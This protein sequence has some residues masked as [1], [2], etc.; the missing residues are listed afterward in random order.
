[1]KAIIMAGGEGRRL[2][3]ISVLRPKPMVS[4]FDRPVMEH[5]IE[6]LKKHEIRD[7]CVTLRYLP[8]VVTDY[9]GDGSEFGVSIEYRIEDEPLGTAGGVRACSDFIGNED[10]LVISGDAVCDFNLKKCID[11]H[12][13]KKSPATIILCEKDEPLEYGLVLTD[14]N[15]RITQFIEKPSWDRVC[16]NAVNTGIYI[17]SSEVLKNIPGDRSYDFG[18]D[19]FPRLLK[20]GVPM[21]AYTAKGYWCDIGSSKAYLR[22]HFDALDGKT[23]LDPYNAPANGVVS[24]SVIP[25]DLKIAPPCYIGK[26]V[27]FESGASIGPYAVI[28]GNS[29]IGSNVKIDHSLIDGAKIGSDSELSGAI[30]CRGAV[31]GRDCVISEGCIIGEKTII[32]QGSFLAD[33]VLVWPNKSVESGDRILYS[34][35]RGGSVSP[36]TLFQGRL[37]GELGTEISFENLIDAGSSLSGFK[38]VLLM[39]NSTPAALAAAS[40]FKAG[41]CAGGAEV[42]DC[43][44]GFESAA[45]YG[46]RHFDMGA[47]VFIRNTGPSLS[48]SFFRGNGRSFTR[49]DE[50][51]V[52][53]SLSGDAVRAPHNRIGQIRNLPDVIEAY[54]L[55]AVKGAFYK[56]KAPCRNPVFVFG[57]SVAALTLKRTLSVLGCPAAKSKAEGVC[58]QISDD[59]FTLIAEEGGEIVSPLQIEVALALLEFEIGSGRVAVLPSSPAAIE[60]IARSSGCTVYKYGRDNEAEAILS[61]QRFFYDAVFAAARLMAGLAVKGETLSHIINRIPKFFVSQRSVRTESGGA[62]VMRGL[63]NSCSEMSLELSEGLSVL[64]DKGRIRISP[65]SG[66]D[67]SISAEAGNEETALELCSEFEKIIKKI[68]RRA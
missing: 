4:L 54:A 2:R 65:R 60:L 7:I 47:A 27:I 35:V 19:L 50:R 31:I 39:S 15:S 40:A 20:E 32:G 9:F 62:F 53:A 58:F 68:D 52:E 12:F 45:A 63:L 56:D 55:A 67:I 49:A 16:T 18:K 21:Y 34:I 66:G 36:S 51:L 24:R 41:V 42:W 28:G 57:D 8:R 1:M 30:V 26:D 33:G 46:A 3:P 6:L 17:L 38:K 13:A 14:G 10:F 44:T 64:S 29:H 59:G 37:A 25:A 5:I 22:S 48:I 23:G 43:E 11:F 61:G